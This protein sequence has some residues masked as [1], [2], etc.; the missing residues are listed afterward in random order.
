[1]AKICSIC[2]K[3][4]QSGNLVSHSHRK[5]RRAWLPNLQKVRLEKGAK[6]IYLC[7]KCLKKQ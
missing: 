6:K 4:P 2:G 3:K 5:T 1:M 7:T